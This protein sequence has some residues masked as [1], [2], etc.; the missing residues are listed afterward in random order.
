MTEKDALLQQL[1]NEFLEEN[2]ALY[3]AFEIDTTETHT[4]ALPA[5]LPVGD[6]YH[7]VEWSLLLGPTLQPKGE[8]NRLL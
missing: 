3:N 7:L 4:L 5:T 1:F 2:G 6:S 8:M